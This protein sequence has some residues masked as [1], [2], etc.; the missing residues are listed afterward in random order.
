[1]HRNLSRRVEVVCPIRD[2]LMRAY[3][4]DEVLHVYLRD[5]VN[6]RN[7]L[8]DGSYRLVERLA[9]EEPFDSQTYFEGREFNP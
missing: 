9:E 4:I 2:P 8:P 7:L 1:M 6:A 5:N 3:L